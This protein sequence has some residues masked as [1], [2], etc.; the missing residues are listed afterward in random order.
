MALAPGARVYMPPEREYGP[1]T[2][3]LVLTSLRELKGVDRPG[4][5]KGLIAMSPLL[6][7]GPMEPRWFYVLRLLVVAWNTPH[8]L[9]NIYLNEMR[10]SIKE[11]PNDWISVENTPTA[12]FL[13]DIAQFPIANRDIFRG[14]LELLMRVPAAYVHMPNSKNLGVR[15]LQ[16]PLLRERALGVRS[17]RADDV[18]EETILWFVRNIDWAMS[19]HVNLLLGKPKEEIALILKEQTRRIKRVVNNLRFAPPQFLSDG[20][21]NPWWTLTYDAFVQYY[22]NTAATQQQ[23]NY[24]KRASPP[25][26]GD[27]DDESASGSSAARP[28]PRT[29]TQS[30]AV[31]DAALVALLENRKEAIINAFDDDFIPENAALDA[32]LRHWDFILYFVVGRMNATITKATPFTIEDLGAMCDMIAVGTRYFLNW[33]TP[34]APGTIE[35]SPMLMDRPDIREYLR[36]FLSDNIPD[37]MVRLARDVYAVGAEAYT[38]R[39]AQDCLLE[40]IKF[41]ARD[42]PEAFY[43]MFEQRSNRGLDTILLE[44]A[45]AGASFANDGQ[46]KA[47]E[48]RAALVLKRPGRLLVPNMQRRTLLSPPPQ[49][50]PPMQQLPQQLPDAE[51]YQP[52]P[53]EQEVY[54]QPP[55]NEEFV[56]LFQE[57]EN[58]ELPQFNISYDQAEEDA[59]AVMRLLEDPQWA[60]V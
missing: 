11:R 52:Q 26:G 42:S 16:Q 55:P 46:Q 50:L 40:T 49:Q 19:Q 18:P 41:V 7:Q 4:M 12:P 37:A 60:T 44:D 21:T 1:L 15:T 30:I 29:T 54:Q 5:K 32:G 38:W 3:Q 43:N 17:S 53:P 36:K 56:P 33:V 28:E 25:G 27:E 9:L 13:D 14:T 34:G 57:S 20:R 24:R 6:R 48:R 58:Y 45:I 35:A 8:V 51:I 10:V 2:P 31:A 39:M 22:P 47:Y 23:G 59:A